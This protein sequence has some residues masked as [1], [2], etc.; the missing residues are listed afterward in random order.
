M[1]C[2]QNRHCRRL[3]EKV[4]HRQR[5]AVSKRRRRPGQ[6]HSFPV[7]AQMQTICIDPK[8]GFGG[9][10]PTPMTPLGCQ[11]LPAWIRTAG[12]DRWGLTPP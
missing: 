1:L 10:T 9:P 8:V 2:R 6:C 3:R 4:R 5:S 11:I 7:S 12:G